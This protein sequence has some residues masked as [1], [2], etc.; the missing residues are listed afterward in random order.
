MSAA[1]ITALRSL[2][3]PLTVQADDLVAY[4][5]LAAD[6]ADDAAAYHMTAEGAPGYTAQPT[7]GSKG[8]GWGSDSGTLSSSYS[9]SDW[10]YENGDTV[11]FSS[12]YGNV[13]LATGDTIYSGVVDLGDTNLKLM[14]LRFNVFDTPTVV[15]TPDVEWR[16]D[17]ITFLRSDSLLSW[18]SYSPGNKSWRYA[19]LKLKI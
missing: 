8:F 2:T 17:S 6:V 3:S 16:G 14:S 13:Q 9:W 19:Q 12:A 11:T 15:T 10:Q 1:S 18:A 4:W 5:P 7:S